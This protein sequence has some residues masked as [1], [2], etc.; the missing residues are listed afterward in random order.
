MQDP[1]LTLGV[2]QDA[3]DSEIRQAYLAAIRRCPPEQDPERFQAIRGAYETV[4]SEKSRLEYALF[5]TELPTPEDLIARLAK[6]DQ[7]GRP[8]IELFREL[9]RGPA[10][11]GRK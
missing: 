1:Y 5:D 4:R 8:G 11:K 6:G 3:S 2:P 7:P 10:Q 9:L